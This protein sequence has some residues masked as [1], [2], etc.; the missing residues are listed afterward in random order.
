MTCRR[1]QNWGS[2]PWDTTLDSW[3]WGHARLGTYSVVWFDFVDPHGVE[4]GS[5]Y[6]SQNGQILS[7]ACSSVRVRP[8]APNAAYPPTTSTGIPGGFTFSLPVPGQGTLEMLAVDGQVVLDAPGVSTR[9]IG[10]I[11]GTLGGQNLDGI[12]LYEQFT[13]AS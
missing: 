11:N 12:S 9:W 8:V 7:T 5:A 4:G 1:A 6:V 13:F 10:K 3:Y 2:Q